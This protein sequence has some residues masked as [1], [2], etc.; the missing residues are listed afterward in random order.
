MRPRVMR[1]VGVS[2]LVRSGVDWGEMVLTDALVVEAVVWPDLL[3][4]DE[5]SGYWV[6][7]VE[8]GLVLGCGWFVA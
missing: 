6:E 4:G 8:G 3:E 5:A 1:S 7:V 2:W